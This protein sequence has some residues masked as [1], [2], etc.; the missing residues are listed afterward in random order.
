MGKGRLEAFTDGV[1]AIAITIMVLELKVPHETDLAGVQASL[2][3]L[4]AYL[5]SFVNVGIFWVNHHHM[6]HATDRI[7]GRV[8]WANLA[9]LFWLSLVP[10]V[11]RWMDEAGFTAWPT[12][13][14]GFV[15][16][17]AAIS[18]TVLLW[19]IVARNGRSSRLAAAVGNDLKGKV[20]LAM[21]ALAI[22]LA[23]VHPWIAIGLYIAVALVWLVPDRRIEKHLKE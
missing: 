11:I 13:A 5:L 22:P 18:Y 4:C 16:M 12:A 15:L 6:M 1:L 8:L 20:S 21:Y 2:P 9:L 3:L 17:M 14:Y 19:T 10:F 23:F 7:D